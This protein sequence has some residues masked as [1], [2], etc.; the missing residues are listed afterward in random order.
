MSDI[1][2]MKQIAAEIDEEVQI[3]NDRRS[4]DA[5]TLAVHIIDIGQ[6]SALLT[7]QV[8][9]FEERLKALEKQADKKT[10]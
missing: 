10:G 9:S 6:L 1:E 3:L 5:D 2:L 7:K 8:V 4:V